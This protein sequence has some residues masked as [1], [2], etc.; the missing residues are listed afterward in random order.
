M[1]AA[2]DLGERAWE[3]SRADFGEAER[4]VGLIRRTSSETTDSRLGTKPRQ[5]AVSPAS[6]LTFGAWGGWP[7]RGIPELA[8]PLSD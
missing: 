1:K 4:G 2:T 8:S 5:E 6:N 7:D 3:F